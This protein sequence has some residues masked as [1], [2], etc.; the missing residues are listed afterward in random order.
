MSTAPNEIRESQM[1]HHRNE[2][3]D[4]RTTPPSE[5]PGES[6]D[7]EAREEAADAV[8]GEAGESDEADGD[9]ISGGRHEDA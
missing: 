9:E 3:S 8:V 1:T 2:E 4:P 7:R 6:G 5:A